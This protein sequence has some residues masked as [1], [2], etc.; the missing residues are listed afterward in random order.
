M[1]ISEHINPYIYPG[2]Q[3]NYNP[4]MEELKTILKD[5]PII[6]IVS[7]IEKVPMEMLTIKSRTTT[8]EKVN[9]KIV[10]HKNLY[11]KISRK[12]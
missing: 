2:T 10:D 11:D 7:F 3:E 6:E 12:E 1:D 8:M 9:G 4:S 5:K